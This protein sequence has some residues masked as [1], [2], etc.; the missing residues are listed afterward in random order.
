M[1]L[2]LSGDLEMVDAIF[3]LYQIPDDFS[4]SSM[5]QINACN[6]VMVWLFAEEL[7]DVSPMDVEGQNIWQ[8]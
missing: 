1:V 2:M 8:P 4:V 5:C 3:P 7:Y 6:A